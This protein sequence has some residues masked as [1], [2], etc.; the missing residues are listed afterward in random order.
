MIRVEIDRAVQACPA[1][2][3]D[4][5]HEHPYAIDRRDGGLL[6]HWHRCEACAGT[7]DEDVELRLIDLEDMEDAYGGFPCLSA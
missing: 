5:G 7:G 1:C 3:G 6:C 2:G 4:G